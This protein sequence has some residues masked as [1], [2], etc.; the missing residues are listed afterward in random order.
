MYDVITVGS[1]TIDVFAYTERSRSI[2][3]KG[4]GDETTYISYPA[5]SKLLIDELDFY[6]GGGGTNTAAGLKKMGLKV[7]YIGR[8]GSDDNGKKVIEYL[9]KEDIDFLGCKS[10]RIGEK[11]GYSIVLDS[12]EKQRTILAFKGANNL[13]DIK[14]IDLSRLD[15]RWFYLCTMVGESFKVLKTL[16]EHAAQNNIKYLFNPSNY[17]AEKGA[18][19]LSS[20]LENAYIIICNNEEAKLLTGEKEPSKIL[21]KMRSFGPKIV[22]V[23]NGPKPV[24]CQDEGGNTYKVSPLEVRIV[25]VT[26][27]GDSFASAFL[28]SFIKEQDVITALKVAVANSSSVLQYKGAKRKLLD[29]PAA[30]RL[31]SEKSISVDIIG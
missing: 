14:D 15:T 8:T 23:T 5:G 3:I 29:Y 27:A 30:K 21:E 20:V 31:I 26:G 9:E 24:Y 16:S 1:N 17:L 28:A 12:I 18:S 13:L 19:Y 6:I 10:S 22:V 11:N 7:G 2:L 4:I 25:E